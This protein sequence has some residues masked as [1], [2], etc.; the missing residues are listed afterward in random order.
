MYRTLCALVIA[1]VCANAP[2]ADA[3]S[4]QERIVIRTADIDSNTASGARMMMR[5]IDH[6]ADLACGRSF[7]RQYPSARRAF[8]RCHER[9]V[10]RAVDQ[11]DTPALRALHGLRPHI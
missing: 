11:I 9:V 6:A 4:R 7:A 8:R 10:A 3:S 5:R 1:V 2:D